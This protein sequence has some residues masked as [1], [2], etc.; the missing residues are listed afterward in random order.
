MYLTHTD[1]LITNN[2]NS[3]VCNHHH[4]K[5][6]GGRALPLYVRNTSSYFAIILIDYIAV[7]RGTA[8]YN[9]KVHFKQIALLL[10]DGL[11]VPLE[12]YA[13]NPYHQTER[14]AW[15]LGGMNTPGTY[16]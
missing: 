14:I 5:G 2:P 4:S 7:H 13:R 9:K 16:T 15:R 10:I 11:P 1:A 6:G 12:H 8:R 3:K